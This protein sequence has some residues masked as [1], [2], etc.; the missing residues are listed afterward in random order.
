MDNLLNELGLELDCNLDVA[1]GNLEE[2]GALDGFRPEDNPD[3]YT[4]R[5]RDG[6]FVMGEEDF[7]EAVDEEIERALSHI[8][9]MSV[10]VLEEKAPLP[11]GGEDPPLNEEG[12]TLKEEVANEVGVEVDEL[13]SYLRDGG[14]N[15]RR[16]KLEEV[17]EAVRDSETFEKPDSYDTIDWVPSAVRHHLTEDVVARYGL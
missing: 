1:V 13:A 16:E 10:P 3:W 9:S 2:F 14:A 8:D 7:P 5:Q 17:V 6:A 11:D 12:E 15:E 4:I